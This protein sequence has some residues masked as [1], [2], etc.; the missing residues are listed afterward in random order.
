MT[1]QKPKSCTNCPAYE[2]GIGFVKPENVSQ[3]TKFALIGQ[4]PGEMEARFD[5]PFFPNAPSGRTLDRWLQGAGLRRS[6]ALISN[7]VWCWLP[8]RKPN[9]VP[10]GNR[11]PKP[12]ETTYCSKHHLLPLLE[13]EG[14]TADDSLIVAVGA[15][16]T[17]ALT[18]LEGPLDKHMGSLKKVKL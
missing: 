9:G 3:D 8:A 16:A 7:I 1:T 11:D 17:R 12:E 18:K 15:P 2:W 10:Q 6:E 4:G 13:D 14:Y 5:R